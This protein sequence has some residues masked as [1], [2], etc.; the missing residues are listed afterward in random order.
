MPAAEQQVI[1]ETVKHDGYPDSHSPPHS[2]YDCKGCD[3]ARKRRR[4]NWAAARELGITGKDQPAKQCK[5]CSAPVYAG[6][7]GAV[8]VWAWNQSPDR[9]VWSVEPR[10]SATAHTYCPRCRAANRDESA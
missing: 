10:P 1:R 5:G 4:K 3:A 9:Q 8:P 7:A 2:N 6:V